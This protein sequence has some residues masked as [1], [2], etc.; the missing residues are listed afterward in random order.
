MVLPLFAPAVNA[1]VTCRLPGVAVKAVGAA[2]GVPVRTLMLA[3]DP[4]PIAFTARKLIL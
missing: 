1:I 2:G 4:G 3:H